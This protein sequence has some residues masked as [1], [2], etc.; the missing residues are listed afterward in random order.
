MTLQVIIVLRYLAVKFV[1]AAFVEFVELALFAN[2]TIPWL[3]SKNPQ[4]P[5]VKRIE[6]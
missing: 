2:A 5:R 1:I 6:E 4:K 3:E